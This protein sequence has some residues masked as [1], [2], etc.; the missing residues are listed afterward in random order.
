MYVRVRICTAFVHTY[1]HTHI[2]THI[3]FSEETIGQKRSLA[4]NQVQGIR[5]NYQSY[6]FRA[7]Q[8]YIDFLE[9]LKMGQKI[10]KSQISRKL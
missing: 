4:I 3:L 10:E 1:A 7:N 6:F 2:R 9:I 8:Y 5:N